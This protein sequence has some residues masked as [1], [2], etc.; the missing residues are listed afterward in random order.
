MSSSDTDLER[1]KK[2]HKGPLAGIAVAVIFACVLLGGFLLWTSYQ[3]GHPAA[4][5]PAEVVAE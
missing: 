3:A 1:Q 5:S 4:E 2:R